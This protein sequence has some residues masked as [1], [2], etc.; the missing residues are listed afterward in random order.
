M[1]AEKI[2]ACIVILQAGMTLTQPYDYRKSSVKSGEDRFSGNFFR[3][4]AQLR[5]HAAGAATVSRTTMGSG[6]RLLK[7]CKAKV[8]SE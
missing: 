4:H 6:Q 2:C 1:P 3:A 8:P 5:G 7:P